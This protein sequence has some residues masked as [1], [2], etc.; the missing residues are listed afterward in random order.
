[1]PMKF[2]NVPSQRS[3]TQ[4]FNAFVILLILSTSLIITGVNAYQ[5]IADNYSRLQTHARV[6]VEMIA[7]NSE[8]AL[9]TRNIRELH[10]IALKLD[11]I[12]EIAYIRFY[13]ADNQLMY[14]H[15]AISGDYQPIS[16]VEQTRPRLLTLLMHRSRYASLTFGKEI[17]GYSQAPDD[18]MLLE[19]NDNSQTHE[20]I[21]RIEYGLLLGPFF[22]T[23]GNAIVN[24]LLVSL[25]ISVFAIFLTVRMTRKITRPARRLADAAIDISNGHF[26][27]QL[28]IKGG[29]EIN[30]LTEAFNKML[31]R[32]SIYRSRIVAQREDL[33][34]KVRLRTK[35][36]EVAT[37]K[38][39]MLAEEAQAANRAK[40]QFLANMSHEIRTPM[41]AI[42]GFSELLLKEGLN[43]QDR[44][45][46]QLIANSS[47][48]LLSLINDILDFSKIEAGKFDL[49]WD[50]FDLYVTLNQIA[51]L[52]SAQAA[53]K[54]VDLCFDVMPGL[55]TWVRGDQA[56]LH[57]IL[58]NLVGNALKFTHRGQVIIRVLALDEN[59]LSVRYRI[60]IQ[61][62][63]IGIEPD[64]LK[65]I[66]EPF[67]QAD[68]SSSRLYGGSGLGLS[69]TRQLVELMG[70]TIDCSSEPGVGSQFAVEL[71]LEK[72]VPAHSE[73]AVS[74]QGC[75]VLIVAQPGAQIDIMARQIQVWSGVAVIATAIHESLLTMREAADN[76]E[77]FDAIVI[78]DRLSGLGVLLAEI[79]ETPRLT[80]LRTVL[81]GNAELSEQADAYLNQPYHLADLQKCI[82]P[83]VLAADNSP[84]LCENSTRCD[85][86]KFPGAAILVVEDNLVNQEL[87]KAILA[88]IECRMTLC[89][90]GAE[91]VELFAEHDFDLILMDCQM[92]V[93]DGYTATEKIRAIE[94]EWQRIKTPIIALTAATISGDRERCTAV[95]MDDFLS[96]PF[97]V[98]DLI[99]KLK[100]W[101]PHKIQS[102][103]IE[104]SE[105]SDH[106]VLDLNALARI[107][108]LDPGGSTVIVAKII[109]IYLET[110]P[111][112]IRTIKQAYAQENRDI[113][114]KTAH[115]LKSS[116]ANLGAETLTAACKRLEAQAFDA[117]WK[118]LSDLITTIENEFDCAA[119]AL[120]AQLDSLS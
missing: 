95:G 4:E 14:R 79:G 71:T 63:G 91:A 15:S 78:D 103:S 39:V 12:G 29:K 51:D 38:A 86:V 70:G 35:A 94:C 98:E 46:V 107:R 9:Y 54:N 10:E 68:E 18:S 49:R 22:R 100:H 2:F 41:N 66:F 17:Y 87:A 102:V 47:Q 11:Q 85:A 83:T 28:K 117:E 34:E 97:I 58:V 56:H 45:Y 16:E 37:D 53:A 65:F 108:G 104:S 61:D 8:Y 27:H 75:K 114:R 115:S 13:D 113:V 33:R 84:G 76:A 72:P 5:S 96:K 30:E 93:M 62:T 64:K 6:L 99:D 36:L 89:A 60:E 1:M 59:A 73:P 42:I 106:S 119:D 19:L 120:R 92:P 21:G 88:G 77:A 82:M 69:I 31:R 74:L 111:E 48:S 105:S 112:Q 43:K 40:S 44:H 23:A 80:G 55:S 109:N 7:I 101:L 25:A 67:T 118:D 24:A 52:F 81:W 110:S 26:D 57:Q 116:S 20:Y 50:N 90:D 3:L 32:L